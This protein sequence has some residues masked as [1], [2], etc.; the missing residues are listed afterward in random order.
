MA[1][2]DAQPGE[3][4]PPPV[5]QSV[6]LLLM[7][8]STRF[9]GLPAERVD[10]EIQHG[11]RRI[12]EA[13][14]LDRSS[15]W[16]TRADDPD[17]FEMTHLFQRPE[18]PPTPARPDARPMFPWVLQQLRERRVVAISRLEELPPAAA[19]DREMFSKYGTRAV[20]IIPFSVGEEMPGALTFASA[21][22]R[23]DWPEATLAWL[24]LIAE[25]FSSALNRARNDRSL[26]ESERRLTESL[27]EVRQLRDQL[28]EQNSQLRR[29]VKELSGHR[30]VIGESPLFQDLLGLAEQVAPTNSTVLLLGETGTGKG[31]IAAKIH[32]LSP[33]RANQMVC[34]NCAAIPAMLLESELFGREKGAYTGALSKQIGRFELAHGSTLFLDEIG[35]LPVELQVKLLHALEN[36][37]IERLGSPKR[38]PIDVRIIAATNRDLEKAMRDGTFRSDLYYRLSAFP[39]K[40]PALRE[41]PEDIPLLV[42]A[43]VQEFAGSIGKRVESVSR[44]SIEALLRYRWPG[45]VRELRNVVERGM[46]LAKGPQL[47][48]VPPGDTFSSSASPVAASVTLN[49]VE[50]EHIES[51]L[52][53]TGGRVRGKGGAAELLGLKPTTLESRM[54]KLGIHRPRAKAPN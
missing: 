7:E 39:I 49:K 45:N 19:T 11:Q 3:G 33:R 40:I 29:E 26:R 15:L 17:A 36:R 5:A 1:K 32:E 18:M 4:Q 54:A 25:V 42:A 47:T 51:V 35:E 22:E 24:K 9:I 8:L 48:L 20:A 13:L 30:R 46:I 14:G 23:E 53:R 37:E 21:R 6:E 43:F 34:V 44:E 31:V 50:R 38:I 41:R 27:A 52:Q 10:T 12:C 28:L 2:R 16:Q